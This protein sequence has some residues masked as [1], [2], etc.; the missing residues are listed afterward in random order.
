MYSAVANVTFTLITETSTQSADLRY[1]ESNSPTT[2]W[3]YFPS[4]LPEGGDAWFNN[5]SGKYNNPVVGNYAWLT[6]IH[7]TGH[8]LGLKHPQTVSGA[9]GAVPANLDSLEYS[10][11]SYRSYTGAST[12]TGLTNA[13]WSFPTTLMLYDMAALQY[14]YGANYNTNSGDTVYTWNPSTGREIHQR[15]GANCAR[16]QYHFHDAVGWR[17]QRH[18]QLFQLHQQPVGQ[19]AAGWLD[20]HLDR[21]VG[22]FGQ[23]PHRHRQYRQCLSLQ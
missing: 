16:R 17:R 3:G 20:H 18:L 4:T 23:W 7:E 19:S 15:R 14:M 22:E 9:F 5:S 13:T 12:T 6:I 2:A 8:L 21:S 1:A 10:V 11:M